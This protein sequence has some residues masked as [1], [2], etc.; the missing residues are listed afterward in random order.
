MIDQKLLDEFQ[1]LFEKSTDKVLLPYEK[2]NTIRIG[3]YAVIY[4]KK[5]N[6]YKIRNVKQD[7]LLMET[8]S[9]SAAIALA[10]TMANNRGKT[11]ELLDLDRIIQKNFMDGVFFKHTI[12]V[13][14]DDAKRFS[15]M[16]RY[17]IAKQ[18]TKDARTRVETILFGSLTK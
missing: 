4:A 11:K 15:A 9:K 8:F 14:K 2:G 7:M 6:S 10:V 13:T 5:Q 12:K 18:K 16:T 1:D 3:E 17:E